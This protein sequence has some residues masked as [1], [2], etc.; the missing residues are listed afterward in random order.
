MNATPNVTPFRLLKRS[1]A[2]ALAERCSVALARWGEAWAALPD[3]AV[4]CSA[5]SEHATT[6]AAASGF[7]CR[8]LADGTPV[9]LTVPATA[10]R[11]LEQLI[12]GLHEMDATC[13]KHLSSQLGA[14]VAETA[15]EELAQQLVHGITGQA[16]H[17]SAPGVPPQQL[18]RHGSGAVL[19]TVQLG[20]R[21]LRI[22]LPGSALPASGKAAQRTSGAALTTL[23]RA[24]AHLP[25]RLSVEV[26]RTELTLGYL[27]TLAVGDV[28]ALPT[29][30]DHTLRV[31]APHDTAVCHAHLGALSGHRAIE[32]IR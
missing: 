22:L 20:E 10:G 25:V 28:L 1:S 4:N 16:S 6:L 27:R 5:A 15:L 31:V 17:T 18:W 7:F 23:H 21:T 24:L 9:W 12:F 32:V 8:L 3:H 14:S 26:S 19:C 30:I 13:D 29:S 11:Y 2:Q